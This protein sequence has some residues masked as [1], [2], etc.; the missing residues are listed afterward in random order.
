MPLCVLD[1]LSVATGQSLGI[2][3][4][5]VL[6]L[7]EDAW[8]NKHAAAVTPCL[9]PRPFVSGQLLLAQIP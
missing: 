5:R 8:H 7:Q 6:L 4:C 1:G 9:T 2:P 3:S